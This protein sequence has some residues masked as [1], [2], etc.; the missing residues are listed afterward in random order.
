[1]WLFRVRAQR[2]G[3][4][5]LQQFYLLDHFAYLVPQDAEEGQFQEGDDTIADY[6]QDV[7]SAP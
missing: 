6:K 4:F 5:R 2:I 1:M 3:H 7:R